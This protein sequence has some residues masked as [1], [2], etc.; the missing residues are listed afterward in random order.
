MDGAGQS[1]H[2]RGVRSFVRSFV[3]KRE[4]GHNEEPGKVCLMPKEGRKEGRREGRP[5]G[6]I[7]LPTGRPDLIVA[8]V[9]FALGVEDTL[10]V[11]GFKVGLGV[12]VDFDGDGGSRSF[13]FEDGKPRGFDEGE[14]E[15]ERKVG[16]PWSVDF[17]GLQRERCPGDGIL[18]LAGFHG[19]DGHRGP[20]DG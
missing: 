12:D 6:L 4:G 15:G 8:T 2:G 10:T 19:A 5:R 18:D 20:E 16:A 9:G 3:R 1:R 13:T 17:P 7:F 14:E 11:A